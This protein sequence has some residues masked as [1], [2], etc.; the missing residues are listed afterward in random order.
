MIINIKTSL[1]T[2]KKYKYT[3]VYSYSSNINTS[4]IIGSPIEEINRCTDREWGV[5]LSKRLS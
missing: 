5:P 1:R 3:C 2:V 4:I